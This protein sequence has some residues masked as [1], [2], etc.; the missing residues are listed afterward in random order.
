VKWSTLASWAWKS[1]QPPDPEDPTEKY[2][3]PALQAWEDVGDWAGLFNEAIPTREEKEPC[4]STSS[5]ERSSTP[6]SRGR[7]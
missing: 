4:S 6:S 3:K 1:L 2:V 5:K 7:S